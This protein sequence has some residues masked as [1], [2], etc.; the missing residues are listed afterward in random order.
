MASLLLLPCELGLLRRLSRLRRASS[1]S[2]SAS[3]RRPAASASPGGSASPWPALRVA[4]LAC[5]ASCSRALSRCDCSACF[6]ALRAASVGCCGAALRCVGALRWRRRARG[7][8]P[9]AATIAVRAASRPR[10]AAAAERPASDGAARCGR[11]RRR[12]TRRARSRRRERRRRRLDRLLRRQRRRGYGSGVRGSVVVTPAEFARQNLRR[13]HHDQLGLVLLRR[14]ALEQQRRESGCRRCRES[15]AASSS[16][17]CSSGRRSRTSGR[18]RSSSSVS[19]RRVLSA[20]MRNPLQ[21][22]AVGEV[23]RADLGPHLQVH[24]VAVHD[25][26]EVQPD[27]EFLVLDGDRQ[28]SRPMPCATG[29]GNSPPA[30]KLASLPL[31]A[32][33]FGSARL[34]NCPFVC[35]AL[36]TAPRSCFVVEQEQVQEVAEDQLA[37]A[38][39]SCR[40]CART[41][42]STG[43]ANCCVVDAAERVLV[44]GRA[45][46]ERRAELGHRAAADLGEAHAQQH[47]VAGGASPAPAAG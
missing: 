29:T 36:I 16:S 18:P 14:L 23:E 11:R 46:E 13:D 37:R 12:R 10:C 34:W 47:L 39:P 15:S 3:R 44:A 38:A 25:R 30:R 45:G 35:S 42:A 17:C 5:S 8:M 24:A 22:D 4:L 21:H 28:R 1:A 33:R 32:T 26:R 6:G 40:S 41:S 7:L 2:A 27:A 19:V 9:A 31:S 20:G 43:A